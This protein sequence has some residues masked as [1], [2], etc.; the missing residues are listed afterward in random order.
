MPVDKVAVARRAAK[1]CMPAVAQHTAAFPRHRRRV[2]QMMVDLRYEYEIDRTVGERQRVGGCLPEHDIPG[3]ALL[4]G[5]I[6]HSSGGIYPD[7]FGTEVGR[8]QFGETPGTAAEIDDRRDRASVY[9]H[10][11]HA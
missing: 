9:V 11:E 7:D 6:Q 2:S 1:A 3:D 10:R 4:S 5:L 8:Q